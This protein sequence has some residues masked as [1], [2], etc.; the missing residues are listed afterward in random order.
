MQKYLTSFSFLPPSPLKAYLLGLAWAD[1]SINSEGTRFSLSSKEEELIQIRAIFYPQGRPL[2]VRQNGLRIL[3]INSSRVVQ[4]LL[5]FGFTTQK[6]YHGKP[7]IPQGYE[8]YFLLGLL[9]GDGCIYMSIEKYPIFRI[10]YSGNH[11]TMELVQAVI[12]SRTGIT[13]ALRQ[14]QNAKDRYINNIKINDHAVCAL[15]VCDAREQSLKFLG[16]L[17]SST[18]GIPYFQ[19]KYQIY[20]TFLNTWNPMMTCPLCERS[21]TPPSSTSRYCE[22]CR[23]LLRRLR[24]R[25]QDHLNRRGIRFPLSALLTEKE[26][27]VIDVAQLG[28]I[29]TLLGNE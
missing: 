15:L 20:Q 28:A 26:R 25:Q 9:D 27:A 1:G 12:A 23:L 19:R 5:N 11:E 18:E 21:F 29:R 2:E 10:F 14:H 4:E 24:N 8:Q 17:Y 16:W 7:I 22:Y 3:H 13:F 6:S